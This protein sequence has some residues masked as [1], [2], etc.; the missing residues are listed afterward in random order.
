MTQILFILLLASA[1]VLV[2]LSPMAA[3]AVSGTAP[4]PVP[5]PRPGCPCMCGKVHIP[6]PFGIGDDCSWKPGFTVS[7]SGSKPYYGNLEISNI[8]LEAGEM[9]VFGPVSYVC[10]NSSK[11]TESSGKVSTYLNL[12][13]TPFMISPTRN[14]FTAIGCSTLAVLKG[15][16]KGWSY[17][18]GCITSC[19]SSELA[20]HDGDKCTGL[21]CCQTSI[22]GNLTLLNL[23]WN[24]GKPFN[25]AWEYS[26]CSYAF[27]AEKGWYNF[28][29]RDAL[30]RFDANDSFAKRVGVGTETIVPLVLDWAMKNGFC[31]AD[32]TADACI[33]AH[34]HCVNATHG[35]GYLCNCS[36]GNP[37]V[38]NGCTNINECDIQ[39]SNSTVYPCA[40]GSTCQDTEGD[41]NC[42]CKFLHRGDGKSEKGCQ[43]II[44]P[45]AIIILGSGGGHYEADGLVYQDQDPGL[46]RMTEAILKAIEDR[47]RK[48]EEAAASAALT[49]RPPSWLAALEIVMRPS[50]VVPLAVLTTV[51]V[52]RSQGW[53]KLELVDL[54][55]IIKDLYGRRRV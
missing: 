46:R 23:R 11:T 10:Y 27:V 29:R 51:A 52:A 37:Y 18:T 20:A 25:P 35:P 38:I 49:A 40:T 22:S 33:S 31:G 26:P 13:C 8:S 28:S 54:G 45:S 19:V 44:P 9:R 21:G 55:E 5:A 53:L 47:R 7:C 41:Y 43:P 1:I 36:K 34:S 4:C 42:K 24:D 12:T 14:E 16:K 48:E 3:G 50:L 30:A 6:F 32:S 39:N 2:E 17:Y 15:R